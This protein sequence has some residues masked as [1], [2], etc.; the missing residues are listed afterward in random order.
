[1]DAKGQLT[2]GLVFGVITILVAVSIG[3]IMFTEINDAAGNQLEGAGTTVSYA[4]NN[5][6]FADN[7]IGIPLYWEDNVQDNDAKV[8]LIR[9]ATGDFIQMA[10]FC[11]DNSDNT[12]DIGYIVDNGT[13]VTS[14][15]D[16][17]K[18]ASLTYKYR[19]WDND[20][21]N[22]LQIE[23]WL[24]RPGGD[25]VNI[26]LEN[27]DSAGT[28]AESTSWT[29]ATKDV[30]DYIN[31]AGT[32][33]VWIVTRMHGYGGASA[34]KGGF[35]ENISVQYDDVKLTID[36]YSNSIGENINVDVSETG[37][38]A[39]PL[40]LLAVI[41]SIFIVILALFKVAG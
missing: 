12:M 26:W 6:T 23:F 35:D 15:L 18:S 41:V 39:F 21:A 28:L 27:R 36:T 11:G 24:E 16:D 5:S 25:N 9:G 3:A 32:Y 38:D 10:N 22:T 31:A 14:L 4:S 29:T 30:T 40:I 17:V 7:V 1:M 33:K 8:T 2:A 19:V 20:N 37:G 13:S 34:E